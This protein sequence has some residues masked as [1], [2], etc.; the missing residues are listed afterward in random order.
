MPAKIFVRVPQMSASIPNEK[1]LTAQGKIEGR[2]F[3]PLLKLQPGWERLKKLRLSIDRGRHRLKPK[4]RSSHLF[5]LPC[6]A[7]PNLGVRRPLAAH[8]PIG[9]PATETL[10]LEIGPA[11]CPILRPSDVE[12]HTSGSALRSAQSIGQTGSRAADRAKSSCRVC[13]RVRALRDLRVWSARGPLALLAHA[14]VPPTP[15][16]SVAAPR[17]RAFPAQSDKKGKPAA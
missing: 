2:R 5:S 6:C 17:C 9:S 8:P 1:H 12:D 3:Y 7:T 4:A 14:A 10:A 16:A 11:L 13:V 15:L